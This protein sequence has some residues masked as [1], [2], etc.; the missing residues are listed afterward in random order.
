MTHIKTQ[1]PAK[2]NLFLRVLDKRIGGYHNIETSFQLI[3]IYD[4]ISFEKITDEIVIESDEDYLKGK[5]NTIYASAIK[6]KEYLSDKKYGVK[7]NIKK[8]IPTGAGMG[9]GSS[10]A[11]STIIALN[12]LWDINLSKEKLSKIAK[13][14]GADVPFFMFGKNA[15]GSGIGDELKEVSSIGDNILIIDPLIHNSSKNMFSLLKEQKVIKNK[16]LYK[17]NH[18]FDIFVESN[19]EVKDFVKKFNNDY[20]IN[21]TGS[22]SCM[23]IRYKNDEEITQIIKK[24]P[25]KWRLFFCKPLQYSPICYI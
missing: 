3:D 7:I 5:D 22:G 16:S 4:L 2:I 13:E 15:L 25:S 1:C 6:V 24:I 11:A 18:F 9:G 21:L 14:I 17:Q 19:K 23:F 12:K 20:A 10:N 8:N